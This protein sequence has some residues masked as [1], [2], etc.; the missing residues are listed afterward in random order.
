MF[1]GENWFQVWMTRFGGNI[2]D[3]GVCHPAFQI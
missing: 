1:G 2:S 3:V